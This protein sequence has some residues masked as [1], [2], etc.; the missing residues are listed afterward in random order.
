MHKRPN[1]FMIFQSRTA[2]GPVFLLDKCAGLAPFLGAATRP[3]IQDATS[4]HQLSVDTCS[5]LFLGRNMAPIFG[6]LSASDSNHCLQSC[7]TIRQFLLAC[8]SNY[9]FGCHQCERFVGYLLSVLLLAP[10]RG[11]CFCMCCHS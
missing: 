8:V 3:Q 5:V 6:P 2:R 7:S 10:C 4:V 9:E 1:T 11:S